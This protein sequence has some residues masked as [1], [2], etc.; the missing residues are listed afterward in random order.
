MAYSKVNNKTQDKD[1]K[2]LNK[3]YNSFKSQLSEF[4]EVYFPENFNDFSEGNPGMMFL[5]MASYVGD[6]LSFYTDTQLKEA[7]LL[8]AQEKENIYNI[9]YAMGYKPRV[10]SAA[11]TDLEIFQLVPS[12]LVDNAYIPDYSYALELNANSTFESTDGPSFYT[13][14]DV[15]FDFSSSFDPTTVS[16]YQY[17]SSN[18][19]EYYLL[20]KKVRAISGEVR[21]QSFTVGDAERFKTLTLFDENIMSIESIIDSEG[22]EYNEVPYLA[23]D[24]MFEEVENTAANDPDLHGFTQQTPYL[25]KVKRVSRRFVSR[26]KSDN[27]LEIQFGAGNSD[28]ADETIIPNPDNIGLGIKDGRNKLDVAYDPSNFLYTRAY[29]QVPSNTTLTIT[30]VVGGGLKSNVNSNTITKI[31]ELDITEK[32][33]LNGG[34]AL[35]IRNSIASSNPEAAK[36]GGARESLEELRMNAMA[37]FGAQQ[38]TVTKDDYLIR[39]LSMPPQLGRVAK[40]YITQDD[41]ISPLTTEPGRI[42]NPLALNLYTLGFDNSKNLTNLNTATK[43]NLSTYLEQYR[44]LTDAINIKNAFV[45]NF[46]VEFEITA[47]KNYNNQEILLDCISELKSYFSID[48]WQI[49]QPIIMAEIENLI[50]GVKG[51]QTLEKLELTNKSGI[52]S[53]YS[54]YKYDFQSSTKK[55]TIYPSLDPCIF[56]LKYPNTDI[57]GKVT[58]Y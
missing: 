20:K 43:I 15:K 21:T 57:K 39:A 13:I 22:N 54:Q 6:V 36:G 40:V 34:M 31:K 17:D 46:A 50:G 35:F 11:S 4:A 2:Y 38:R 19:P 33:N 53:G 9:A 41:Q 26:F 16:I 7:F 29:G 51:V 45:V 1:V 18:N 58:T 32:P 8:T 12:K 49:N 23:Q 5:E 10:T 47:Y 30:Y 27:T 28:K 52:T 14:N 56:E 37:N 3:D 55:G 25:L 24:T 42:P 44:M 48:M